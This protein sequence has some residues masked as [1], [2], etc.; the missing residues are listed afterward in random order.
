MMTSEELAPLVNK[1]KKRV[2]VPI[3]SL[4]HLNLLNNRI[5]WKQA[6]EKIKENAIVLEGDST[7]GYIFKNDGKFCY[8]P[9]DNIMNI[10][11]VKAFQE[12]FE[13]EKL[14]HEISKE[15][16]ELRRKFMSELSN[17]SKS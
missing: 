15:E 1:N 7:I 17:D 8:L 9:V 16:N 12:N 10:P 5:P 14:D 2:D 4:N 13:N 3:E 11:L 6:R